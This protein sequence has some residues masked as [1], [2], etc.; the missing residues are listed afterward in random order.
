L[1]LLG[2]KLMCNVIFFIYFS[3]ASLQTSICTQI[4][5]QVF[6]NFQAANIL[7]SD[8][9]SC[10][11]AIIGRELAAKSNHLKIHHLVLQTT[12]ISRKI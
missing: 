9:P 2:V 11:W 4:Y 8:C 6:W 10:I 7:W 5:F 12:L 3:V 1:G